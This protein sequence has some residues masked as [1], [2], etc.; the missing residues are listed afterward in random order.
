MA[1]GKVILG[2]LA[3]AA[4]G[5]IAGILLAPGKGSETRKDLSKRGRDTVDNLKSKVSDLVDTVADK[6]LSGSEGKKG[7][8]K[9]DSGLE[10]T[11]STASNLAPGAPSP[12]FHT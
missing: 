8:S 7:G 1:K 12:D 10:R 6:Y 5:A 3:G 9:G 4:V 11:R 2:L